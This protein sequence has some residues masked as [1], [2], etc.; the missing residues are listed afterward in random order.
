MVQVCLRLTR[1]SRLALMLATISAAQFRASIQ[2][3]VS[4]T[5]GGLRPD[6]TVTV[7]NTETG[8]EEK[9]TTSN[10]GFYRVAGLPPGNYT[11]SAEKSGY[12]KK[13]L[14]SLS[15][16]A[17]TTQ[18]VDIVLEVGEVS[19]VVTVAQEAAPLLQTENAN[20][21]KTITTQEVLRLPQASRD[22]YQLIRLAPGVFGEGARTADG[23][24]ANLPNTSGP[25]G[26]GVSIFQTENQVPISANGQ[27]VSANSF[28]IDGVSVNSQTWGGAAVIT[29][30]Q[31]SV[32]EVSVT[33]STYSAEDGRNSGA[34][35]KVVTQNGTNDFHGSAFFKYN[36]PAWNAF[37]KGFTIPGTTR[38]VAPQRVENR[39]KTFG[40]SLGGRAIRDRLFFFF[41]YEG[42]RSSSNNTYQGFVET[43]Q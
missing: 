1:A 40:G 34:Q 19:A 8:K 22:P 18:G 27:R 4:A 36:T 33:S 21:D 16:N 7:T 29:P 28:Q 9:A 10:E 14:E 37:N 13:I 25:G 41:S 24:A 12:K 35:V 5:S 43:P 20:V 26:S 39:D 30:S 3:T 42:L 2:G 11:V 32:K 31:E 23:N 6:A 17:E 38:G 15:V